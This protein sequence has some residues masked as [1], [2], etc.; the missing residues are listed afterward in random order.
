MFESYCKIDKE[1]CGYKVSLAGIYIIIVLLIAFILRLFACVT[2]PVIN[3]D[4]ALYIHQAR[5]IHYGQWQSLTSCGLSYLSV[6]PILIAI[7]YYPVQDWI[8]SA[9][10]ISCFF[11]IGMLI[12]LWLIARH[13][14][15]ERISALLTLIFAV[16][17]MFVSS[18]ADIIRDPI[19]WFFLILGMYFFTARTARS[20][21]VLLPLACV[22]YIM[23]VWSRVESLLFPIISVMYLGYVEEE[24]IKKII[25][26]MSPILIG[27]FMILSIGILSG[28]SVS[29]LHRI[30]EVPEK[31]TGPVAQYKELRNELKDL[32]SEY[33]NERLGF[34]LSEARRSIWLI[35]VGTLINRMLEAFFYPFFLICIVGI[36]GLREK[37]EEDPFLIYFVMLILSALLLLY[38]HTLHKW[39]AENRFF[40]IM[41]FPS[42]I[43]SGFGLEKILNLLDLRF[44][45]KDMQIFV[46]VA[47]LLITTTLPKNLVI[48]DGDKMV[49]REIGEYLSEI[50]KPDK[51]ILIS[52]TANTQRWVSFYANLN[53]NG[54]PCPEALP[55]YCWEFF[56][57]DYDGF[58]S[59][60]RKNN[61]G[62][63]LWV[64]KHWSKQ[65]FDLF[66][67]SYQK[68]LKLLKSWQHK[69]TGDMILFKVIR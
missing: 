68:D 10:I 47:L 37:L 38:L 16:T 7:V 26:F 61:I 60:L 9:R 52:A 19:A 41:I 57:D 66:K 33:R 45:D 27:G 53:Y 23:A 35:A 22:A 59:N 36:M 69:D 39:I 15:E 25:M 44:P 58:M 31:I 14:F 12:P 67:S 55:E 64:E 17:P 24:K 65:R 11:S 2:T 21:I 56:P 48:R 43:F 30:S 40:A 49:F 13:F 34:F 54:A 63:F 6:Y 50:V 8:I 1:E 32:S 3:P 46:I 29:K 18:S 62:Y 28:V 20:D 42:M 51:E 4:G 5:A